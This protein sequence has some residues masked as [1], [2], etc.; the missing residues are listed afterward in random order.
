[1]AEDLGKGCG[2]ASGESDLDRLL[3]EAARAGDRG[4]FDELYRR[5]YSSARSFACR[6]LGSAQ[7]ADDLVAESFTKVLQ[8]IIAG[9]GPTTAFRSYLLTTVRTTFYKQLAGQRMVDRQVELSELV[10]PSVEGDPVLDKLDAELAAMA[11][12]SL[13]ERW[14]T[15]LVRIE[16]EKQPTTVVADF[17]GIQANAVAALAF[18]AREALRVAYVQMHVKATVDEACRESSSNLAAWSCGRLSRGLRFRVQQ[19]VAGCAGCTTAANEVAE[20]LALLRRSVPLAVTVPVPLSRQ[21]DCEGQQREQHRAGT[22][23]A[24]KPVS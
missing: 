19:H 23:E 3:V 12:A 1:M 21:G 5:H 20:L 2:S 8:R 13:P 17:L 16:V 15:V 14:R 11:L 9:G 22:P 24:L 6:L 4:A 7:N 10:L 18:R